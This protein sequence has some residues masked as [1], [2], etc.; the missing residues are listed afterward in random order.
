MK[1]ISPHNDLTLMFVKSH[2]PVQTGEVVNLGDG[3]IATVTGGRPP[4]TENSTG[5]IYVRFENGVTGEFFPHV[6][7]AKW[8]TALEIEEH[9]QGRASHDPE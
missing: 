4:H 5:R 8:M 9:Q 6:V 1:I 3:R 7:G 2:L